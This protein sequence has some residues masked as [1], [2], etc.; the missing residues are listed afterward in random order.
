LKKEGFDMMKS[1]ISVSLFLF[2][3]N[4]CFG[5]F[6]GWNFDNQ[7]TAPE[8]KGAFE[9]NYR[10]GKRLK[11]PVEIKKDGTI[12]AVS[13]SF[14]GAVRVS[15]PRKFVDT[16]RGNLIAMLSEGAARFLFFP[17][18]GHCH[19]FG[20][21]SIKEERLSLSPEERFNSLLNDPRIGALCHGSEYLAIRRNE[22]QEVL[23]WQRKR[24]V[25]IWFDGR[26]IEILPL[27]SDGIVVN[28]SDLSGMSE[29]ECGLSFAANSNGAFILVGSSLEYG[30][31][32]TMFDVAFQCPF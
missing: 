9:R 16:L 2:F 26:G 14:D 13:N 24:N 11:G 6:Y 4:P 18:M 3:A 1:I 15:V 29:L 17:D 19:F 27:P 25:I 8:M 23:D 31:A 32:T 10:N 22:S 20:P 12:I 5:E 21:R 7:F 30:G 28:I